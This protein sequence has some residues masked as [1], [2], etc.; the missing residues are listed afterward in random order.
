MPL[1][2]RERKTQILGNVGLL[3]TIELTQE[4]NTFD[5]DRQAIEYPVD[6]RQCFQQDGSFFGR[7]R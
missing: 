5:H 1:D 3:Q 7:D 6:F 2:G 4:E